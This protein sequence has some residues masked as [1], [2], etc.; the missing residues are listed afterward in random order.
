LVKYSSKY[1]PQYPID[2]MTK[3]VARLSVIAE[4]SELSKDF[5]ADV[6]RDDS[7]PDEVKKKIFM[8]GV[9]GAIGATALS[10]SSNSEAFFDFT[11]GQVDDAWNA[12]LLGGLKTLGSKIADEASKVAKEAYKEQ[13]SAWKRTAG[14]ETDATAEDATQT[15]ATQ[16]AIHDD[17][18]KHDDQI[19]NK[20]RTEASQVPPDACAAETATMILFN[21]YPVVNKL[22][23]HNM[24]VDLAEILGN[25]WEQTG[26]HFL[27]LDKNG[28]DKDKK[29]KRETVAKVR[30]NNPEDEHL[31][32]DHLSKKGTL[33]ESEASQAKDKI[34]VITAPLAGKGRQANNEKMKTDLGVEH[35]LER[36]QFLEAFTL[37]T[38]IRERS[39]AMREGNK[40]DFDS[41]EESINALKN[42]K[43]KR[44]RVFYPGFKKLLDEEKKENGGVL[45]V[46]GLYKFLV[47]RRFTP[48]YNEAI[49]N[50]GSQPAPY[51]KSMIAIDNDKRR[52]E[53]EIAL[54]KEETNLLLAMLTDIRLMKKDL[55]PI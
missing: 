16:I 44:D 53:H 12:T 29:T 49:L 24:Y 40:A 51:L 18:K 19:E 21:R 42:S 31:D 23:Q 46:L 14:I 10:Y 3:R 36:S 8:A 20:K 45:S 15:R 28:N 11:G 1:K 25:A 37:I 22:A 34:K 13:L 55:S 9:I 47:D 6:V 52:F 27:N 7:L 30:E 17:A 26:D 39:L 43:D 38:S 33:S 50:L 4:M 48:D 35:E 5:N 54:R 32:K 2:E 41:L